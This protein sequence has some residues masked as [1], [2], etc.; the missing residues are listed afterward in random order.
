MIIY[1]LLIRLLAKN[2]VVNCKNVQTSLI[3]NVV[4]ETL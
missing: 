2:I 4:E 1:S 3:T